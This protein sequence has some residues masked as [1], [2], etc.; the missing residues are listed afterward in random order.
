MKSWTRRLAVSAGLSVAAIAIA[1]PLT[2][3]PGTAS[4]E[5]S[6]TQLAAVTD[7][8]A[9]G[10]HKLPEAL[11][12][13]LKAAWASPDG[14]RVAALRAVLDKAISGAY[15]EQ[16]AARAT[17]VK[18][19]MDGLPAA[20]RTDV[21]AAIELSQDQRRAAFKDIRAKVKA[22]GYGDVK[23]PLRRFRFLHQRG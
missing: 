11:K 7:P 16:V 9:G 8:V 15:G 3:G 18:A 1:V 14:Q 20:L 23:A 4:A 21:Q 6:L 10:H 17:K 2:A 5:T 13:D 19:R 12:A 22:G